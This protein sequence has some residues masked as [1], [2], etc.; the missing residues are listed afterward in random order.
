MARGPRKRRPRQPEAE[1]ARAARSARWLV[2]AVLLVTVGVFAET[3]QFPWID[4]DT[5][6]QVSENP[7]VLGGLTFDGIRWALDSGSTGNWIPLTRISH[8]LDVSLFGAVSGPHHLMSA[9]IHAANAALLFYLLFAVSGYPWRSFFVALVF[10][11]HPLHVE[12]VVWINQRKD[13][14]SA[15]FVLLSI[16]VYGRYAQRPS[17][18]RY[19][20]VVVAFV[21]ALM[22]K[23][24]AVTLPL[25]LILLDFWPLR[26]LAVGAADAGDSGARFAPL[27]S[28][29]AA[30]IE[31]SPLLLA[32][33]GVAAISFMAQRAAGAM[34]GL[35]AI[36][37]T[38]RLANALVSYGVYVKQTLWPTG[39]AVFYPMPAEPRVLAASVIAVALLV[40]G[41]IFARMRST[42]PYLIVGYLWFLVAL[43]PVLGLV[44]VGLGA[45]ADRYMYLA[46]TGLVVALVWWMADLIRSRP[47][48]RPMTMAASVA[49]CV[50]LAAV[51]TRQVGHWQS[52][53][54]LFEHALAVTENNPVAHNGV[55]L[56]LRAAG[57][58]EEAAEHYVKAISIW[59][60][61]GRA[62][63]NLGEI[64]YAQ[65]RIAE[66]E[67]RFRAATAANPN[68]R[69]AQSN[70]GTT[71]RTMGRFNEAVAAFQ[72]AIK[73][74]PQ[75]GPS[76]MGLALAHEGAGR[77]DKA[78]AAALAALRLAPGDEELRSAGRSLL[79]RL[80]RADAAA[81]FA[82]QEPGGP[83]PGQALFDQGNA[84]V[85]QG[86]FSE[87]VDAFER[88]A[89][90]G[91]QNPHVFANLGAA[92]ASMARYPEA[93]E[94]FKVALRLDPTLTEVQDNLDLALDLLDSGGGG[95]FGS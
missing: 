94:A 50:V 35:N 71:L 3:R 14:L 46:Q 59:P 13:V 79:L 52:T 70:L 27:P 23:P 54:T 29:R 26:R 51:T 38:D 6:A 24:M 84:L 2:V 90:L 22:A 9:F 64:L 40:C 15:F 87:A 53:S 82:G 91:S 39:L 30:V 47:R 85:A 62:H 77:A 20:L 17:I 48:L 21:C 19:A 44:R 61:F 37:F 18:R 68:L 78:V 65:G 73:I 75:H 7:N 83:D 92:L 32:A 4:Y 45:H 80:G 36:P 63:N 33:A 28:L 74:R 10:A 60:W 43:V 72:T 12:S 31:K 89:A 56:E 66:A 69:Q 34:S 41:V 25:L 67:A 57:K 88:A 42:R 11:V 1:P 16:L 8:M 93:I 86:D 95:L 58:L 5:P 55:G 49:V 76:H 81:K